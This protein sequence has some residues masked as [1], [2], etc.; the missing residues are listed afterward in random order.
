MLLSL[1]VLVKAFLWLSECCPWICSFA[2]K[3]YAEEGIGLNFICE[4]VSLW[5]YNQG[6]LTWTFPGIH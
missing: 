5:L 1:A 2:Y 6:I 4:K 3:F